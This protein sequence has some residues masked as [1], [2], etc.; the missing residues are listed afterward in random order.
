MPHHKAF[1]PLGDLMSKMFA[2]PKHLDHHNEQHMFMMN[3]MPQQVPVSNTWG[4]PRQVTIKPKQFNIFEQEPI[5]TFTRWL[6]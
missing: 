6:S 5:P 3:Q 4:A 1:D 2:P